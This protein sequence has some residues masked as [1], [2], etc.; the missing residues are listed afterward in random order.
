MQNGA[1]E[2]N[3]ESFDKG[4]AALVATTFDIETW[5]ADGIYYA[6]KQFALSQMRA[7]VLVSADTPHEAIMRAYMELTYGKEQ[8]D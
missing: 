8:A 7:W 4:L 2:M 6:R 5:E 3:K 1:T